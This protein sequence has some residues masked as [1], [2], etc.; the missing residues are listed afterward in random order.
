MS[1]I[2]S[3]VREDLRGFA[4]YGSARTERLQGEVWLNANESAWA[5]AGD[6][7]GGCRRY[8]EPQPRPL[9]EALARLYGCAPEQVLVGR[10]SDEAIDLLVRALCR[11][12]RDAV[13][14][15]PPVFGMYAVSARLQGAPLLEVPL[16]DGADGFAPDLEA[17]AATALERGARLVFLCAP[18]NPTGNGIALEDISRL[19]EALQGHALLA[20]DEA[21]G[22]FSDHASA[23]GLMERHANL[24]VLRTLSK[25]HA[26]A[27]A[28]IGALLAAPELVAV[29]QR[30]Q[31]PYPLPTPCV[32]LALGSLTPEVL[33]RTAAHVDLVRTERARLARALAALPGVVRVYPSQANFLLVRFG[34]AAGAFSALLEAGIVVRDQRAAPQ[35]A[36]A[37]RITV[38]TA[39]QNRRVVQA[40]SAAAGAAATETHAGAGEPQ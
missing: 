17:V 38:G 31:A 18:G 21:Y 33:A 9:V 15:M 5:G 30:C 12:G 34:D 7:A 11:P 27:G 8:P 40:L 23:V 26:L 4:G 24:A 1:G 14:V 37:L 39:E 28:R 25:A 6:P 16:V 2:L 13:L 22:E 29:L 36:D 32:D 20:V 35:L 3:L 10:G 19:A